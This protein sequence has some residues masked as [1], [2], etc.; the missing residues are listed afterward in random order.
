MTISLENLGTVNTNKVYIGNLAIW[1]S[2]RTPVG[3]SF[4]GQRVCRQNDWSTTTGKLLNDI[5]PDHSLRVSG[6]EFQKLL[7]QAELDN[8]KEMNL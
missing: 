2:Y 5:E 3:F 4:H 8:A 6:E 7:A 1:F